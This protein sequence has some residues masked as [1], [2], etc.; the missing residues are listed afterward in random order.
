MTNAR[1]MPNLLL[2]VF[3]MLTITGLALLCIAVVAKLLQEAVHKAEDAA[4]R[5]QTTKSLK[6]LGAGQEN[7]HSRHASPARQGK[8]VP[9]DAGS[10]ALSEKQ[11][12]NRAI[13]YKDEW[14]KTNPEKAL[15]GASISEIEKTE[16]GWH[17]TFEGGVLPGEAEGESRHFLHVYITGAGKI[18][19]VAREP[20]EAP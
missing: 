9:A 3:V 14:Q 11:V 15:D 2:A 12:R 13:Q 5:E 1:R 4:H 20:N 6:Q 18:I 16:D 19:K 8:D 17:V 10:G 7:D